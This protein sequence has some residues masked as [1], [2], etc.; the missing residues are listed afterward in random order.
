[1]LL[2]C[3]FECMLLHLVQGSFLKNCDKLHYGS[4]REFPLAYG[5]LIC[6][7]SIFNSCHLLYNVTATLC[8]VMKYIHEKFSAAFV[9]ICLH[10]LLQEPLIEAR[11]CG[12][13]SFIESIEFNRASLACALKN[14]GWER[15]YLNSTLEVL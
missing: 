7:L 5:V 14:T 6:A 4:E 2:Q 15:C 10:S 9:V 3:T 13:E 12:L 8:I 1:M 11:N